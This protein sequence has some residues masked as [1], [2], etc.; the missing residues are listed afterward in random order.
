MDIPL[1]N[2]FFALVILFVLL[3]VYYLDACEQA[4]NAV[5]RILG[6]NTLLKEELLEKILESDDIAL[7]TIFEGRLFRL[8]LFFVG[9]RRDNDIEMACFLLDRLYHCDELEVRSE[10]LNSANLLARRF[11]YEFL[12]KSLRQRFVDF[13][14]IAHET[15][16]VREHYRS[17]RIA[18]TDELSQKG[19]IKGFDVESLSSG[20]EKIRVEFIRKKAKTSNI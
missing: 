14:A 17:I 18:C 16:K 19:E 15:D 1:A 8:T 20:E 12:R 11:Q 6:Q 7:R 13:L 9:G 3:H 2:T 5:L 4:E 10:Y